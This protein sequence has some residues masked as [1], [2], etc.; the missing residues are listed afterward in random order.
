MG[1]RDTMRLSQKEIEQYGLVVDGKPEPKQQDPSIKGM[2]DLI[3]AIKDQ[4]RLQADSGKQLLVA[5]LDQLN[6][7]MAKIGA[8]G[9]KDIEF[10]VIRDSKGLIQTIKAKVM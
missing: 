4:G 2:D 6:G 1:V 5:L 8:T 3:A 10:S 7:A 9:P